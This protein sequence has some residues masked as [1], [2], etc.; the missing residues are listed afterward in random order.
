MGQCTEQIIS[1][2]FRFYHYFIL[3]IDFSKQDEMTKNVREIH[4]GLFEKAYN[5]QPKFDR[6]ALNLGRRDRDISQ[7]W[8]SANGGQWQTREISE[9]ISQMEH[10]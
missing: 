1:L 6:L 7:L 2:T 4:Q 10:W 8:Q 9:T 3:R 5:D